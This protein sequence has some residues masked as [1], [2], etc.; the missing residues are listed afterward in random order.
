M[1]QIRILPIVLAL[2]I[3]GCATAEKHYSW[4]DVGEVVHPKVESPEG[5]LKVYTQ[6]EDNAPSYTEDRYYLHTP[7][8]IFTESGQKVRYVDNR[9][10]EPT[11]VS[12]PP[13]KYIVVPEK[14]FKKNQ[15]I[16]AVIENQKFTEIDLDK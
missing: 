4:K 15:S 6:T 3:S 11:V 14:G 9:K 7:Y 13:G 5:Y 16:G 12:L 2:M 8:T 10:E 1:K